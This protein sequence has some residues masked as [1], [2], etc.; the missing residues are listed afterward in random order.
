MSQLLE[1]ARDHAAFRARMAKAVA[2]E[3]TAMWRQVD[4]GRI[5]ESWLSA[6]ARLLV[7]LTGAQRVVAGRADSYLDEV[8]DAQGVDPVREGSFVP[9]SLSGVASDGRELTTLLYRPAVTALLGVQSGATVERAL[10]GGQAA[11]DMIVQTQVAD[12]GR[13]ADEVAMAVRP[14]VHGWIRMITPPAC[15]RCAVLAGKFFRWNTGFERHPSCHCVHIPAGEDAKG[16]VRTDPKAYFN[17]LTAAE[18]D[19]VFTQAGAEAIRLGSDIAQVVNA[20]RGARGLSPAGARL[21]AAEVKVL[22][23]GRNRGHLEPVTA[24]GQQLL[25]TNEGTTVRG[26]AGVRLGAKV[27]GFKK[28]GGRYRS[29]K[30]PRLMPEQVLQI[31]AGNRDEAIRLLKRNGYVL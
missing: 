5:Q 19:R 17:S 16:D 13:V 21:T 7:L 6:L 18:Q 2:G 10:A 25:I 20:R 12:A 4:P 31:A 14:A 30:A 11:L 26:L 28:A 9:A 22:R 15:S 24:F 1:V 29:A 23:G 27:D 3:A 8:L